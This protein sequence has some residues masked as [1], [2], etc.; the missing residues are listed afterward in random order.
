M[1]KRLGQEAWGGETY[2]DQP[3]L[4]PSPFDWK[5]AAYVYVAGIAGSS[6]IIATMADRLGDRRDESIV[7]NG[8][9]VALAGAL[10]GAPLL[11]VDLKTPERFYNMLRIFRTTS[12]M[13]F[14]SYILTGFGATSA[15]SALGH[16]VGERRRDGSRS[17]MRRAAD[18]VQVPAAFLGA[19]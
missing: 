8:R 9:A 12:P 4:K 6:Q 5:V 10:I 17:A 13:S 14:G 1:N 18:M 3:P 11:I 7:R 2:Y 16:L 15:L 19:G